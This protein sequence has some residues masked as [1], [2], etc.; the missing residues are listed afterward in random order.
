ML[1]LTVVVGIISFYL[2]SYY[3]GKNL[4]YTFFMQLKDIAPSFII[5]II[6]SSTVFFLRYLPV[7]YWIIFPLQLAIG[8]ISFIVICELIKL[9]EYVELKELCMTFFK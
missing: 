2:N 5:S 9:P 3:T 1:V 4:G 8:V 6:I 7:S